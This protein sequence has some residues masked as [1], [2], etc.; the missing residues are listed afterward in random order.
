MFIGV[1][2]FFVTETTKYVDNINNTIVQ[3]QRIT[4]LTV[5]YV[6]LK[7]AVQMKNL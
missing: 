5:L 4:M 3:V 6:N 2:F 7:I 1:F